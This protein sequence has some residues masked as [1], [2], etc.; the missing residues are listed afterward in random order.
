MKKVLI[1]TRY[2]RIWHWLQ[3]LFILTLAVTGFEI[4]G[5]YHFLG[6]LKASMLHNLTGW[7]LVVLYLFTIFWFMVTGQWKQYKPTT[8]FLKEM[9]RFYTSGIFKGEPHPVEK[10]ELSRLNPLQRFTYVGL[11]LGLIPLQIITG[12][13]YLYFKSLSGTF[14]EGLS[15]ETLAVIHTLLA[16]LFVA[17]VIGHIYLTTTGHTL[18]SNIKAMITGYEELED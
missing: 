13:I 17:F 12:L 1:Y 10:T 7:A 15:L 16:F 4:H 6:F 9:I 14:L 18:F 5:T 2:N 11:K 3:V 8:K